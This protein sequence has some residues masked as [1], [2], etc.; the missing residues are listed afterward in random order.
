MPITDKLDQR[1][2]NFATGV[3]VAIRSTDAVGSGVRQTYLFYQCVYESGHILWRY[4]INCGEPSDANNI[5]GCYSWSTWCAGSLLTG[6]HTRYGD[7]WLYRQTSISWWSKIECKSLAIIGEK[8]MIERITSYGPHHSVWV[9][10]C[11]LDRRKRRG[12]GLK[13]KIKMLNAGTGLKIQQIYVIS[14]FLLFFW[15]CSKFC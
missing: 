9:T 3:T 10:F 8:Y 5:F 11:L 7:R 13:P 15:I 1:D 2:L 4:D 6:S 12:R 14:F